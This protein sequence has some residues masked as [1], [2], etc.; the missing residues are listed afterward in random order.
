MLM[1]M[2][3]EVPSVVLVRSDPELSEKDEEGCR[4]VVIE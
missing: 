2:A 4:D 1:A 3:S